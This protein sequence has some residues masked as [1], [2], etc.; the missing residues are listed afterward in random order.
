MS[1]DV[2]RAEQEEIFRRAWHYAGP[3]AWVGRAGRALP[4]SR[5]GR[6]A[7]RRARP[8]RDAPRF[9]NVCRH[10]GSVIVSERGK[11]ETL[12]CPYHAWTYDLDGRLRSAPRSEREESFEP[13]EL[14][15]VP[16]SVSEWGP[17]VFVN[18]DPG[19]APLADALGDVPAV[20]SGLGQTG[21]IEKFA[22]LG[23]CLPVR[24]Q[25]WTVSCFGSARRTASRRTGRSPSRTTSSARTCPTPTPPS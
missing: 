5:R 7:R 23:N 8:R 9:G 14:G 16:A 1:P 21:P 25:M 6:S 13:G 4:V 2:L 22:E 18:A 20:R 19:A 12:Q 17:F 10:R 3:A 15:L 24:V 11:R